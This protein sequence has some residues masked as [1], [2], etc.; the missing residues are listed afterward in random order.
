MNALTG[1]HHRISVRA[2]DCQ[3]EPQPETAEK[4]TAICSDLNLDV[5][6]PRRGGG[7]VVTD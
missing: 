7:C 3:Q 5:S 1:Q 6:T 4:P 2:G